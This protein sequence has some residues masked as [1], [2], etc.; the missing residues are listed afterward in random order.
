MDQRC[1]FRPAVN[2]LEQRLALN[3]SFGHAVAAE[4]LG[5]RIAAVVPQVHHGHHASGGHHTGGGHHS[6]GGHDTGGGH[7]VSGGR[8]HR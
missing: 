7:H 3:G 4:G 1:K 8:H 6:S 2:G 5:A